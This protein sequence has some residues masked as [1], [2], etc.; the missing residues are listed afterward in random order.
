MDTYEILVERSK[1]YEGK[2]AAFAKGYV[3]SITGLDET[4]GMRREFRAGR[5]D[6]NDP[7]RKA[8]CSWHDV[9]AVPAGLYEISEGG[10]R[11]Y[12]VVYSGEDRMRCTTITAERAQAMASM[13]STGKTYDEA[14]RATR[15]AAV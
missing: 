11:E 14:R 7:Y 6:C 8:R 15:P 9:Y 3:A 4:Y 2:S 10:T 13:M 12:V 5:P 1:G